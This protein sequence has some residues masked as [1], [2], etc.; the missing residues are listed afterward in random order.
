MKRGLGM[1]YYS[2]ATSRILW[3]GDTNWA[4]YA[5]AYCLQWKPQRAKTVFFHFTSSICKS[6]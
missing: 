4:W 5:T 1:T 2:T 3:N 6:I